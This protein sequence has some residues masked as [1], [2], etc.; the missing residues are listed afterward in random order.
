MALHRLHLFI[1]CDFFRKKSSDFSLI[2]AYINIDF[3]TYPLHIS[4]SKVKYT[5]QFFVI[6]GTHSPSQMIHNYRW[7]AII[8]YQTEYFCKNDLRSTSLL[9]EYWSQSPLPHI[10]IS[11]HM[12]IDRLLT[13]HV[14]S[15]LIKRSVIFVVWIFGLVNWMMGLLCLNRVTVLHGT[16]RQPP[17]GEKS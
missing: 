15:R 8:K 7:V 11:N 1:I 3:T 13:G 14:A 16:C 4:F 6:M 2:T 12:K 17:S 9:G 5:V 10:V